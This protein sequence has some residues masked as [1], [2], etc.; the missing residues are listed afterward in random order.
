VSDLALPLRR[1]IEEHGPISIARFMTLALAHPTKGYY[2]RRDPLGATGDFVTAPEVSQLFGELIGLALAQHWLDLGRP[3]RIL[4]AELGPGRGTLLADALRAARAAKGFLEAAAIHLV[5]TSPTLRER[6]A[7]ALPGLNVRWH[8]ELAGVPEEA[9]LFLVANE[10]LDALP[11]RQ[12]VRH[13]GSWHERLVATDE[14]GGFRFTLAGRSSPLPRIAAAEADELPEGTLLELGPA[15]EALAEAIAG[16]LVAQGGM[17]LLI[18]YGSDAPLMTGDTFQAVRHHRKVSPL[19][20]PGEVDLSA[21]VDFHAVAGRAMAAGVDVHGPVGQG[22]LLQRLGIGL[23]LARLAERAT[24]EQRRALESGCAR[25][26][27]PE[28][29]G[30]LFKAMALT[31]PGAPVPPGFLPEEKRQP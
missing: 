15:R 18:D 3:A 20:A 13:R 29:M 9:P 11:I 1:L 22:V 10:F 21:H 23:R 7:A 14:T 5:E 28:Q 30:E 12:F 2:P 4:L 19:E 25:L 31:A 8:D 6:Q 16:R 27:E 24:A 17:A 26:V